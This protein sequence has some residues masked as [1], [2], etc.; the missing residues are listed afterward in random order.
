MAQY[1]RTAYINHLGRIVDEEVPPPILHPSVA[2]DIS[3]V[4][5]YVGIFELCGKI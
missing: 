2:S 5:T 4:E 3:W 1:I